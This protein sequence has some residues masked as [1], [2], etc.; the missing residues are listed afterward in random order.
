MGGQG[1]PSRMVYRLTYVIDVIISAS[2]AVS[3]VIIV[4]CAFDCFEEVGPAD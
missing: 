3:V 1:V 2:Q 4:H